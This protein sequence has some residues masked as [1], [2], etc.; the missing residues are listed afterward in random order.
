MQGE[1][2][3]GLV[4]GVSRIAAADRVGDVFRCR[5]PRLPWT[6][7][8]ARGSPGPLSLPRGSPGPLSLPEAPL[9]LSLCPEAPLDL[10]LCPEAP[11]D[12][13]LCPEAPLREQLGPWLAVWFDSSCL[14]RDSHLE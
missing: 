13:S 7:L 12:L 4:A 8:S 14:V 2:G 11:L 10:S 3:V 6:S 5:S 9:D 1:Y